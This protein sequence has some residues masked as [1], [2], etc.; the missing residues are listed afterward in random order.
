VCVIT[1]DLSSWEVFWNGSSFQ[2][3]PRPSNTGP[4]E[5]ATGTFDTTT[6][7]YELNWASQIKQGPFNG[8]KGYWHVE[9]EYVGSTVVPIPAA[10]WLFGSGL[11]GLAG[12][13]RRRKAA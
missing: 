8:V 7:H 6:N 13:M 9:G 1:V 12:A 4:F 3:G 2:Q 5:L 10:A 11:L